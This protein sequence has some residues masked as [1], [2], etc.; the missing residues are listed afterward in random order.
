MLSE[1]SQTLKQTSRGKKK[2]KTHRHRGQSGC[3]QWG[4]GRGESHYRSRGLGGTYY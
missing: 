4:E 2:E 3:Y 1:I